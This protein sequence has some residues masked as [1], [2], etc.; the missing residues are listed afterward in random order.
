MTT[1]LI[2]ATELSAGYPKSTRVLRELNFSLEPGLI[3]GLIGAN[4]A[5]KNTLL[6]VLAGQL[7]HNG[8]VEVF[9]TD[10]FDN[11]AVLDRTLCSRVLT[12]RSPTTGR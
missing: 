4:G 7:Q 6:R 5:G 1:P 10:P 11:P 9:G 12:P 8:G 3:H 2:K